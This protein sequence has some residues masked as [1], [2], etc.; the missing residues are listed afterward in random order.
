VRLVAYTPEPDVQVC[1]ALL[2]AGSGAPLGRCVARARELAREDAEALRRLV[3][4]SLER[5]TAFDPPPRS[6]EA[7]TFTFEI[8]LS[9]SAFAQLKRHRMTTQIKAPYDPDLPCTLPESVRRTDMAGDFQRVFDA[10]ARA[11]RGLAEEVG[12]AAAEYALTNAHR[13]RVLLCCN[14]REVYHLARIRMDRHAQ[15]DIRAIGGDIVEVVR[16]V[17][18]ASAALACGKDAFVRRRAELYG[19]R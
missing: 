15:W 7:A 5:H 10:S 13:R 17:A 14:L 4:S 6:F 8:E 1:A 11:Y 18:P 9:A 16:A 19:Q 2:F 3:L 12:A